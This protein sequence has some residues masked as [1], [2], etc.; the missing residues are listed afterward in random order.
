MSKS[1]QNKIILNY[2]LHLQKLIL[3]FLPKCFLLSKTFI[4]IVS[5]CDT[6]MI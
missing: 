3:I 5:L 1:S 6:I 2:V 4:Q